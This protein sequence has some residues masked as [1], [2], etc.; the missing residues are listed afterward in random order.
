MPTEFDACDRIAGFPPASIQTAMFWAGL[1]GGRHHLKCVCNAL[2]CG[3][4][5]AT[6]V[7]DELERQGFLTRGDEGM[8]HVTFVHDRDTAVVAETSVLV[9]AALRAQSGQLA[10]RAFG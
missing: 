8:S 1:L 7:L 9:Q 4:R 5:R 2:G 3:P 6:E 10:L